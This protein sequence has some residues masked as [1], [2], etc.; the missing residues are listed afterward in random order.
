MKSINKDLV[1][2]DGDVLRISANNSNFKMIIKC[3][4]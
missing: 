1:L 4:G 3:I 2:K